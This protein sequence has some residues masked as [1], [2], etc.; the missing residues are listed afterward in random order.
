[1]RITQSDEPGTQEKAL[2]I[3]FCG[4]VMTGRCIDQVLPHPS[5][6]ELHEPYVR[7]A[8]EYVRLAR[9]QGRRFPYRVDSPYIWGDATEE[10]EQRSPDLRVINLETS[11][12]TSDLF[13]PGKGVHYRMHA[14][15]VPVLRTAKID[16]CCL[17]ITTSW[18]GDIPDRKKRWRA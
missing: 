11:I 7:H 17:A 13:W 6:P 18:I 10:W 1:M 2:T 9:Q 4:D 8:Q 5:D 3:C 15:N 12:T 14:R 16:C